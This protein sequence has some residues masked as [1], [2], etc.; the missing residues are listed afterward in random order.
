MSTLHTTLILTGNAKFIATVQWNK[1]F[2][3]EYNSLLLFNET[4]NVNL[5]TFTSLKS[6]KGLIFYY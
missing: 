4:E 3:I 2:K 1:D 5:N 6:K